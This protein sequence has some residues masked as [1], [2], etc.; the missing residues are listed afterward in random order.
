MCRQRHHDVERPTAPQSGRSLSVAYILLR[1]G[2]R[3]RTRSL[4]PTA[5]GSRSSRGPGHGRSWARN[6]PPQPVLGPT[7]RPPL[8]REHRVIA[9]G[10]SIIGVIANAAPY[11]GLVTSLAARARAPEAQLPFT[12][13]CE[14]LYSAGRN[15]RAAQIT[16][17]VGGQGPVGDLSFHRLLRLACVA[18][19]R[20]HK[21][22]QRLAPSGGHR[23]TWVSGTN[24]G[25]LAGC[26]SRQVWVGH[27][28]IAEHL[29]VQTCAAGRRSLGGLF[30]C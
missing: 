1:A 25:S 18:Q 3:W 6:S 28:V 9:A 26:R 4:A 16:W 19:A 17:L 22:C 12:R 27:G 29:F 24:R 13:A 21:R 23:A 5:R 20:G 15:G 30:E 10:P 11:Y 2:L 14:D 7:G 8:R